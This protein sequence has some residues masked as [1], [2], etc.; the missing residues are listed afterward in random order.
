MQDL[1]VAELAECL[2]MPPLP[3]RQSSLE[4][5]G[6]RSKIDFSGRATRVG[7]RAPHENS[8]CRFTTGFRK[9]SGT[10]SRAVQEPVS[11]AFQELV[12]ARFQNRFRRD[13]RSG[14]LWFASYC[15][16]ET[17]WSNS[18]GSSEGT[19]ATRTPASLKLFIFA[20]AVPSVPVMIA[21]A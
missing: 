13:S 12:S 17:C 10:V 14:S 19:S 11:T 6:T 21:P 20:S 2:Q 18:L 16:G 15:N 7:P 9:S 3:W 8:R 1:R 4:E 5:T